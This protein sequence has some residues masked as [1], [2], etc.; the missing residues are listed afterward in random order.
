[1]IVKEMNEIISENIQKIADFGNNGVPFHATKT[2]G[3]MTMGANLT[4]TSQISYIYNPIMRSFYNPRLF[5]IFGVIPTATGNVTFPR[6]TSG[7]GEG[8]FG[9]QTEGS[10]K[11]QVDY[12]VTMVNATLPFIA[13]Y[14][15]VSRQMLQD[16]PFLSAYLQ[17]SLIE[18]WNRAVNTRYL[19]AIASSGTA[20][21]TSA[22]VTAEK[23]VD[24]VAQHG[25][26]GL[27]QANLILTTHAVWASILKTL[28]TNAAYS[29]PGGITIGASGETRIMGIPV[30]PHSQCTASKVYVLNT[31]AFKTAQAS[32]LNIRS[33]ETD[34]D[35]FIKNLVTY[36]CEARIDLISFQP[37][38][39]VY[40]AS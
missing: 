34:Q 17:T 28:P 5:E 32:G 16:L 20:G 37:T 7:I 6:A 9:S 30:V 2:V 21:S 26:L 4:G 25:A 22:S 40:G 33:T 1:M 13:G 29:V 12:D 36:R 23:I 19:N 39:A 35:D 11:A 14:S 27:G 38:A 8:S 24:Y 18:D 3:N 15:K 10:A 31:D